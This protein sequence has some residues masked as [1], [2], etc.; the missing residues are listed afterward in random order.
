MIIDSRGRSRLDVNIMKN[1]VIIPTYNEITHIEKLLSEISCSYPEL[2]ILVVD[3]NSPDG[4]GRAAELFSGTHPRIKVLHRKIKT[5]LGGAYTEGFRYALSQNPPYERIIQMDAD[6]SHDPGYLKELVS[7][8]KD[9]HISIGS[10]YIS[11]GRIA[12]WKLSRRIFSY[13]ANLFVH[14]WLRLKVRDCTSG[15]RCFRREVLA[16]LKPETLKS[17]GYFFQVEVLAH[18]L[19]CGYTFEEIPIVFIERKGG[20]TKLG[21]YEIWEAIC[22]VLILGFLMRK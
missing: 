13:A 10:R 8:T 12:D 7:A 2:D 18:C 21:F 9:K 4:T 5:G 15:F 1:I 22:G 16:D 6:F 20:Q 14:F 11:G 3:D 19:R 17:S